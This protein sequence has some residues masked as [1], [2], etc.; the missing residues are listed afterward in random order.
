[1]T[2]KKLSVGILGAGISG[3]SIAYALAQKGI[4][5]TVYE[6]KDEVG[7]AIQSVRINDWLVE[8]GP[9][10]LMVKSPE[11]RTLLEEI[12]LGDNILEANPAAQKRFVVKN[13][14][15]S[16]LPNSIGNFLATPLL[17]MRAK[18]SLLKEPF[19]SS[20]ANED[21][22]IANFVE[23][24]LGKEVLDYG[25]NPFVSGVYAG[26]PKELSIRHTFSSLWEMEQTHGSLLKGMFNKDRSN[27]TQKRSLISFKEGNQMLPKALA[28]MLKG[29]LYT[30][31]NIQSVQKK[32][33]YWIVKGLSNNE[34]FEHHHHCVVSTIPVYNIPKIFNS[35]HFQDLA[36]L[37]YAPLSVFALGFKSNQID[38][39]LDGFGMLIPEKENYK[40]L[41]ALFSST[42]FPGRA[43]ENHHLLTCF[44]GGDRNPK[45][46]QK[47]ESELQS[48][49][50]SELDELLNITGDPAFSYHRYWGNAIPQYKL[51]HDHYLS[52]MKKIEKEFEG[53][54]L[55]GNFRNGVSVPDCISSGFETAHKVH[56]FLQ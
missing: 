22:S 5:A 51:G 38:H 18:L 12:G 41:G 29:P 44:I 40:L 45:I 52:L 21:E 16:P 2:N 17:S 26:D 49:L 19:V 54:F 56:A 1:M 28:S 7:G 42:L 47:P 25:I 10:T 37:P 24:R 4:E 50:L 6:K 34:S 39:S 33:D 14:K 20:S 32:H 23:R 53:L 48:I 46:A 9:K 36:K 3:L 13:G 31:T 11:I 43:P 35:E 8:E 27:A 30:S 55:D 15:L